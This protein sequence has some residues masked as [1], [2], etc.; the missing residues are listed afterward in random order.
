MVILAVAMSAGCE[1]ARQE[2]PGVASAGGATASARPTADLLATWVE[3]QRKLARCIREAGWP[4]DDPNAKGELNFF[5]SGKNEKTNPQ[6]QAAMDKCKDF[7]KPYPQELI[8][9]E[10]QSPEQI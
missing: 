4:V 9:A 8:E 2:T 1:S 3:D 5:P 6:F 10:P 7:Q